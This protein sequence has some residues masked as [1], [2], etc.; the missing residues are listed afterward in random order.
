[1]EVFWHFIKYLT[2]NDAVVDYYYEYLTDKPY[3][4][5]ISISLNNN[6][7][8]LKLVGKSEVK[9]Y[10]YDMNNRLI[11]DYKCSIDERILHVFD[12]YSDKSDEQLIVDLS[13]RKGKE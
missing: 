5:H 1:M 11:Y 13:V 7:H 3:Y 12:K 4:F 2:D 9:Y 6:K 8:L 10:V